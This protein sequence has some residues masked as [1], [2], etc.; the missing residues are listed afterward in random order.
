ML[1]A[2]SRIL[3]SFVALLVP[4]D[5]QHTTDKYGEAGFF[6]LFWL[7][8]AFQLLL[9]FVCHFVSALS[10]IFP[11]SWLMVVLAVAKPLG[12]LLGAVTLW[13]TDFACAMCTGSAW[14]LSGL[15]G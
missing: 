5:S 11:V 8:Q 9:L 3:Q 10:P 7:P 1:H 4:A 14:M 13:A 2:I 15:P 12:A 6:M